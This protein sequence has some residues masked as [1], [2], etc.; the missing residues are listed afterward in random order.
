MT[1]SL[2]VRLGIFALLWWVLTE[3]ANHSWWMGGIMA[4][5]AALINS[6]MTPPQ[7]F[8]F[9]GLFHFVPFFIWHSLKGGI[10]VAWRAF[11][12]NMAISPALVTYPLRLPSGSP[13]I[14]MTNA[15]SLL[16]GTLAADL[17]ESVL[18]VHVLDGQGAYRS[19]LALLEQKIAAVYN[20]PLRLA[21]HAINSTIT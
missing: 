18:K 17:E 2:I 10:D 15:I 20:V 5:I 14:F 21:S 1:L 11:R 16:P 19:D 9:R 7:S 12:P 3:G 6:R 13:Q 8:S 4:L